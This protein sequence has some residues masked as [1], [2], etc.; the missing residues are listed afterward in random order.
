[1]IWTHIY[2]LMIKLATLFLS[3]ILFVSIPFFVDNELV[4]IILS[5]FI[6]G[7]LYIFFLRTLGSYFY[8][9]FTLKM[10]INYSQAK[11]M[12]D[13]FSPLTL[14]DLNW[15]PL[16]DLKNVEE[17]DKYAVALERLEK[18]KEEKRIARK[19]QIDDFKNS[20]SFGKV[21]EIIFGLIVLTCFVISH[22]NL[23]PASYLI[24]FYC[25]LLNENSYPPM[26]IGSFLSLIVLV[27]YI[28][29]KRRL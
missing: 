2:D 20:T 4:L 17:K 28:I 16:K 23:P 19:K 26:L 12:N 29:I 21:L 13:A 10:K 5:I 7:I 9:R 14:T 3:I 8:S 25:D 15:L 1:M 22:Y 18:W 24:S 27:P 6:S 11:K